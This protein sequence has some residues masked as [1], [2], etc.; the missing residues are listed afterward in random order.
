MNYENDKTPESQD[1]ADSTD[2]P[3]IDSSEMAL[4]YLTC[5]QD[6]ANAYLGALMVTDYRARPLHFAFVSPIRPT[7]IQKILY[8]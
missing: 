2:M 4:C 1:S 8:G 3:T 6:A 7:R 5:P